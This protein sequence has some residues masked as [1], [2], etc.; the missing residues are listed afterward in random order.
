MFTLCKTSWIRAAVTLRRVIST[1][2]GGRISVLL[3]EE[4][5][6]YV[7]G[8]REGVTPSCPIKPMINAALSREQL[9]RRR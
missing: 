5:V 3:L 7:W 2:R 9:R 1:S 8:R 6:R 4:H